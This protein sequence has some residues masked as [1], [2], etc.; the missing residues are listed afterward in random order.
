MIYLLDLSHLIVFVGSARGLFT[1]P[2]GIFCYCSPVATY[3]L[4]DL[5][6]TILASGDTSFTQT[7]CR[8]RCIYSVSRITSISSLVS[9]VLQLL[10]QSPDDRYITSM[11]RGVYR[12]NPLSWNLTG[13][14]DLE[15]C[16]G[17]LG[18]VPPASPMKPPTLDKF[19]SGRVPRH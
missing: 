2:P 11:N 19:P 3:I 12:Y 17:T 18:I 4:Q 13:R 15:D 9:R 6:M 16:S 10:I 8:H 5:I 14:S 1:C 7:S